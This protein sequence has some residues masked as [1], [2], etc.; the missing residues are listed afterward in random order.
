MNFWL[1]LGFTGQLIFGLRF[2]IQWICSER[3]KESY[4]PVAFWYCSIVG[5]L[6]L[7][8]YAISI[9]DPVFILGQSVG[10]IIYT[11]NLILIRNKR[12]KQNDSGGLSQPPF[13]L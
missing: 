2:L 10:V 12:L 13:G 7:F 11:R 6:I 8:I 5:G 4:I 1:I 3:R 9:K